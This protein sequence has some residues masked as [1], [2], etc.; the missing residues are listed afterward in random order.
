MNQ[1]DFKS[2]YG[3]YL[4]VFS[5]LLLTAFAIHNPGMSIHLFNQ[6]SDYMMHYE[7]YQKINNFL[8][9]MCYIAGVGYG[10]KAA[11][12]MK[13]HHETA[14]KTPLLQPVTL[15]IIAALLLGLPTMMT[16]TTE[17]NFGTINDVQA[18]NIQH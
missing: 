7:N 3:F 10:I 9:A 14:G 13:E 1:S 6:F 2:G 4:I 17:C 8:C 15:G 18:S 11:L 5:L 16:V 12:K